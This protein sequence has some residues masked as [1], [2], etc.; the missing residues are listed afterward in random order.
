MKGCT[1]SKLEQ[2]PLKSMVKVGFEQPKSV[3]MNS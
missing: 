2:I 1:P 3:T